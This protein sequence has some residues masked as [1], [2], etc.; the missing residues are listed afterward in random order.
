MKNYYV[1]FHYTVEVQ[2][3]DQEQADG[4]AWADFTGNF[5]VLSVGDFVSSEPQEQWWEAT[6]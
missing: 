1:T 6:A 5:D 4:L 2:A 3:E